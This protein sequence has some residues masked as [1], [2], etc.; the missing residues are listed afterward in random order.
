MDDRFVEAKLSHARTT[1]GRLRASCRAN[2]QLRLLNIVWP[3]LGQSAAYVQVTGN[4]IQQRELYFRLELRGFARESTTLY[5]PGGREFESL[6]ARQIR[7]IS[8]SY[9]DIASGQRS[10]RC[11]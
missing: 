1:V 8:E 2:P 7:W 6:R 11:S 10:T 9:R 3:R 4:N 5:E